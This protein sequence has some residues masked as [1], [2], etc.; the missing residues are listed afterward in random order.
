MLEWENVIKKIC[1]IAGE[2]SGDLH[3]AS[4]VKAIHQLDKTVS[5][6]GLGG[7]GL[8]ALG[9]K[10]VAPP[11]LNVVGFTEVVLRFSH[12]LR[13]Y[14][15]V[16]KA[17]R[18]SRPNL[19]ILIDYPDMNLRLA[20]IAH[21]EKIP[22]FY[23]ISPQVW[24]W[25]SARIKT[26]ARY[27]DRLAVILPFEEAFYEGYGI[28]VDFVG[29]P[30]LDTLPGDHLGREGSSD[31][32]PRR[33]GLLPGSRPA[34]VKAL[35]P[36]LLETAVRL[37][38]VYQKGVEFVMPIA[39]T[40]DAQRIQEI[41]SPFLQSGLLITVSPGNS[42]QVLASCHHALV[43]SGTVTLEAAILGIPILILYKISRINYWIA[44]RIIHVPY[45][46]LV[47]WVAG[48]KIIPEYIQ[49]EARSEVLAAACRRFLEDPLYYQ[50]IKTGLL[51]V[52]ESLG[53]P[54]ASFR[55]AQIALEMAQTPKRS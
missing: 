28:K 46:G 17:L 23:Y 32:T 53:R 12:I 21:Q 27:V 25:R 36:L 39:P 44:K 33:I 10:M 8:Q 1:I 37:Q 40:I 48:Q 38:Q 55:A 24:A 5:F 11:P 20:K 4:L 26:I 15:K 47:N 7:T 34:E 29:H 18:E 54:G 41:V 51:Q 19:I 50:K 43:A 13:A 31:K 49:H 30:L 35:L 9:V 45:I 14:H 16:K 3:G 2:A 52:K 6:F 22:V 42:Q